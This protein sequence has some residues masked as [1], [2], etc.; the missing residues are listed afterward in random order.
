R[1]SS[2]SPGPG[3][4]RAE[5]RVVEAVAWAVTRAASYGVFRPHCL[6][7][8]M[9]IQ[10]MLRRRGI[11]AGG[12]RIGVRRRDGEFQAHAWFEIDGV[13]V[14]DSR[15]H[16]QTFPRVTDIRLVDF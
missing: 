6:V 4:S 2:D 8:S 10:H 13:V 1:D 5:W 14:G 9:A 12:L 15:Q 7:R 3:L 16:V 11:A